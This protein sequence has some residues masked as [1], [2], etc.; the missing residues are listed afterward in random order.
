MKA[1]KCPAAESPK[2]LTANSMAICTSTWAMIL[3]F[4]PSGSL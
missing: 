4:E 3:P 2:S 1:M